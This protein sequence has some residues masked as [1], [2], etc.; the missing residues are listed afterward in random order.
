MDNYLISALPRKSNAAVTSG[1]RTTALRRPALRIRADHIRSTRAHHLTSDCSVRSTDMHCE[2]RTAFGHRSKESSCQDS[3]ES[4]HP[5][6]F[7]GAT[8]DP[9]DEEAGP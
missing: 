1:R 6:R 2:Q 8:S 9:T 5:G 4:D 3:P 7:S